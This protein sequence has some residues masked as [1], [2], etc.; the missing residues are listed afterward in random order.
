MIIKYLMLVECEVNEPAGMTPAQVV[1]EGRL[2]LPDHFASGNPT[3]ITSHETES[4]IPLMGI[5][6]NVRRSRH[7]RGCPSFPYVLCARCAQLNDTV[8]SA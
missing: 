8:Y 2:A 7:C 1:E 4:V 6:P 3:V 5:P